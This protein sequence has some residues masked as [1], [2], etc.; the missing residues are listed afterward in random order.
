MH[1]ISYLSRGQVRSA[2][3]VGELGLDL[4][5]S[6]ELFLKDHKYAGLSFDSLPVSLSEL[7]LLGSE[8]MKF[9]NDA[10]DWV[11]SNFSLSQLTASE[12][13]VA[14]NIHEVAILAPIPR[15]GKL[16]CIAGNY[17]AANKLESPEYP[18]VF[19]KP[20]SGVIG[21]QQRIVIP[22]LA[23]NVA[24]E[25][26]LAIVIGKCER[27]LISMD[28]S[29]AIAGY[30]IANDLGDRLLEKRSSQWTSGKMYDTFTPMGP[31]LITPEELGDTNNLALYAKVNDQVTQ[32]G[33]TSQM[34]F[35][36]PQLISYLST[37]TTLV[38][39]DLILT[40]SPKLMDGESNPSIVIRPGDIVQVEIER[41]ATLTNP[42][43]D[44]NEVD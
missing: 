10:T 40:G 16:I 5:Y 11:L 23:E 7:L 41:I 36:V 27:H 38:P 8:G 3:Q 39:G 30:T 35:D 4:N 12:N 2:R 43:I 25:V 28:A 32:K 18:T 21:N 31:F 42:A 19:L 9:S 15:P 29:T 44:E 13:K 24:C 34:F 14:F 1:L 22:R 33:N 20:S 17:P 26:E 6:A 37:L